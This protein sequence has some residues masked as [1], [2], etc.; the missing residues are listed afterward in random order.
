MKELMNVKNHEVMYE[1]IDECKG[2][3]INEWMNWWK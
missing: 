2:S 3:W 1:R